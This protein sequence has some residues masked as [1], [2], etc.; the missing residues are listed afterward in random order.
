MHYCLS[1]P[2]W[3]VVLARDCPQVTSLRFDAVGTSRWCANLLKT[4][5]PLESKHPIVTV[6][7]AQSGYFDVDGTLHLSSSCRSHAFVQP[8]GTELVMQEIAHGNVRERWQ[9]CLDGDQLIWSIEQ[10][11]FAETTVADGFFPGLFF[12]A[13]AGWGEATVFQLWD[14][15]CAHDEFYGLDYAEDIGGKPSASRRVTTRAGIW[16]VA[17]LLSHACPNGDL[18]VSVTGHLKKGEGLNCMSVLAQSACCEP[19]GSRTMRK[20]EVVRLTMILQPMAAETGLTLD[21]RLN[22]PL[23]LTSAV[24]RR[25]FDTHANCAILADTAGWRFG[26]EPSGYVAPFTIHMQSELLK[27]GVPG[28]AFGHDCL[29][30]HRVLAMEVRQMAEHCAAH[31]MIGPGYLNDTSLDQLPSFLLALRDSLLLSGVRAE[32]ERLWPGAQRA[33]DELRAMLERGGGLIFTERTTGNDYWD[34]IRRDGWI[35]YVN[36]LAHAGLQA[37]E[38]I[39][40]WLGRDAERIA[41]GALADNLHRE[42]N[43]RFW[44][45]ERGFY[46]DWIDKIG[47]PHFFL[48][49]GPQLQGVTTGLVPPDRAHRLVETIRRRRHELGAAWENCFSLQMNFYDAEQFAVVPSAM[50]FGQTMNGGCLVSWNYYWIGA[51]AAVGFVEEA[52]ESWQRV[53]RRFGQTS[54]VEGCNYWDFAGQPSRTKPAGEELISYEPFLSDQGLVSAAL[55]RW[56]LGIEPRFEGIGVNPVLPAAALPP[57]VKLRHLGREV[58]IEIRDNRRTVLR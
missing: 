11:W 47:Q 12:A 42:F 5:T 45:E 29:D 30:A 37:F 34:W 56:L 41:A 38:E 9:I 25:F 54:L 7:G 19:H 35:G 14:R 40:R 55:P 39:A 31:G 44:D 48:Y 21:V 6:C 18:R 23:G 36:L 32:A 1:N 8:G 50:R 24:N 28:G 17:K 52:I 43:Q 53:V 51:L 15:D 49:A 26:N 4:G 16:S 22:G 57:T 27:W 46:A 3:E 10:H 20:G 33:V 2:F 58:T 13:H